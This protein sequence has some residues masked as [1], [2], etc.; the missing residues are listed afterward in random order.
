MSL[1]IVILNEAE[2]LMPRERGL[3]AIIGG[4]RPP[5]LLG[6]SYGVKIPH[7]VRNDRW[8]KRSE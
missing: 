5:L 2:N 1:F 8:R 4:H 6:Y 3:S 7:C